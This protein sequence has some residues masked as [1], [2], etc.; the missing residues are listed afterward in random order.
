VLADLRSRRSKATCTLCHFPSKHT[1]LYKI[2]RR[3]SIHAWSRQQKPACWICNAV[4][5]R[6]LRGVARH[7]AIDELSNSLAKQSPEIIHVSLHMLPTASTD[8]F[9][10]RRLCCSASWSDKSLSCPANVLF[11]FST[12]AL[13]SSVSLARSACFSSLFA[14]LSFLAFRRFLHPQKAMFKSSHALCPWRI[15]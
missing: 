10:A 6:H 8:L 9:S 1:M 4:G 7:I 5:S 3:L 12:S 2:P 13:F 15:S 11:S 14:C